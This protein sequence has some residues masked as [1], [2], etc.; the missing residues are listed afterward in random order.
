MR[1]EGFSVLNQVIRIDSALS[2]IFLAVHYEKGRLRF[3]GDHQ[4]KNTNEN[5]TL[6]ITT[7]SKITYKN[8][9]YGYRVIL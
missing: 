8:T 2:I 5:K 4:G 1:N 9:K 7:S 3:N 6:L